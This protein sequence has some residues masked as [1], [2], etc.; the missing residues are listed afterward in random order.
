MQA[1]GVKSE[2]AG[3]AQAGGEKP[4]ECK[5]LAASQIAEKPF[6]DPHLD[7]SG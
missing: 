4:R 2:R 5:A 1:G 3:A 7:L 6:P